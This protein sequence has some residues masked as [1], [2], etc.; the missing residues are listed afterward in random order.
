LQYPFIFRETWS[1][2]LRECFEIYSSWGDELL[3]I[4]PACGGDACGEF[5]KHVRGEWRRESRADDDAV[6]AGVLPDPRPR[7]RTR[8][9]YV[10]IR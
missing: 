10:A 3:V 6:A 1:H 7:A 9:K 5:V 4:L 8:S 2:V